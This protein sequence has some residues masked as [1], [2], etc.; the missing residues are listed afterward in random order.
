MN[1]TA[2]LDVQM[3]V[4]QVTETVEVTGAAPILQTETT[5]VSTLIDATS[6]DKLPLA[7]RNYV[8]LT[9]L[10]PGAVHPCPHVL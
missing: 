3:K 4:G 8:Q 6:T 9:L 7:T 5:E 10:S 1:Q 2:R